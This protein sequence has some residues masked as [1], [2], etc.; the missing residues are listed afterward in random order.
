[1]VARWNG[2]TVGEHAFSV[3]QHSVVVEEIVAHIQPDVAP[4][5]RL[6]ALLHDASEYVIGDMISPFKAALGVD[7]R[8]FEDRLEAAI[9]IRF[10][11]PAKMPAA[12]KTL[13]KQADRACAFFE[14]TQLA[15]FAHAEALDIF[16]PPP[17][18]YSLRIE[19]WAPSLAQA[20]YVQRFHTLSEAAGYSPAP[21]AFDTE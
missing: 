10:G 11:L 3:A 9:H 20:R 21:A 12:I 5:W 14:A 2:Q 17:V 15:G 18:G 19:P 4:R 13:I 7:Y 16:D 6:A 8:T 1:R